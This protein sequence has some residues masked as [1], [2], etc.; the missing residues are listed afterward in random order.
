MTEA[1]KTCPKCLEEK[2]VG[3]YWFRK[4][5]QQPASRCKPCSVEAN[6][7]WRLDNPE[8][9]RERYQREKMQIR[10]R[11]LI[12]KYGVSLSD[13]DSMLHAQNGHCAICPRRE[14]EQRHG[15]FH[16]DHCHQSGAV[17]GLLCRGCNHML[18]HV[19]DNTAVL[20]RAI[21]YLSLKSL[22]SSDEPSSPTSSN[23]D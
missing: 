1:L 13:Y 9:G 3:E 2:P 15:V 18:G 6:K 16:V 19:R 21:D 5:R 20:G 12:R 11:H 14:S 4:S 10:E 17:R 7:Q 22:N 23:S 8:H